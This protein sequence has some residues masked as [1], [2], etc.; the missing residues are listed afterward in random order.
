MLMHFHDGASPSPAALQDLVGDFHGRV[1]LV[2]VDADRQPALAA[3]YD[4]RSLPTVLVVRD[5]QV[6][7]RV[8][9]PAPRALLQSLLAARAPRAA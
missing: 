1:T 3:W 9:G 5:G 7:D 8:I 6:L 2:D 4:V